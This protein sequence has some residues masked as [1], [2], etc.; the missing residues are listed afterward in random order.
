M[1]GIKKVVCKNLYLYYYVPAL[2][3]LQPPE[4]TPP[5]PSPDAHQDHGPTLTEPISHSP[6][7]HPSKAYDVHVAIPSVFCG[8][9]PAWC[10]PSIT[11]VEC[12]QCGVRE[13]SPVW[14]EGTITIMFI[15]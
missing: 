1:W 10:E 6:S 14:S 2:P 3:T 8:V 13:P 12:H 15:L 7:P 5:H 9:S 11:S 4:P